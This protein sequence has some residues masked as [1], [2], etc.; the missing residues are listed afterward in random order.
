MTQTEMKYR[1]LE[2]SKALERRFET[3][4]QK[5]VINDRD[6]FSRTDGMI[7]AVD[8]LLSFGA[9]VI[10]Y[11][12]NADEAKKN[13]FEDGDLFYIEDMDEETMYNSMI[14]EIEQ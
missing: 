1:L 14:Q 10:E 12:E 9:L 6:C 3:L 8:F 4:F 5:C 2:R 13:R 7:F 11:A